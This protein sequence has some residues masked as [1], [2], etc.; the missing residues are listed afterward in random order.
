MFLISW[1]NPTVEYR[2][3][4]WDDYVTDGLF[5]AIRVTK[6]I[7]GEKKLNAVAWCVGGTLLGSAMGVMQKKRDASIGSATFLTTLLDFSDPGQ[8]GILLN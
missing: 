7:T 3:I 1:A 6:D 4:G 8:L 5:E 2:D